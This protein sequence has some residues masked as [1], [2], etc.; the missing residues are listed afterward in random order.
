[1]KQMFGL[2]DKHIQSIHSVFKKYGDIEQAILYGSRAK[3]T[4]RNG[5]DIDLTLKGE[6]LNLTTLF[7]IEDE[8]DD[9]LIPHTVDMSIYT[10]IDNPEL[11]DH[12]KRVGIV[13]YEREK[14]DEK[15]M[16]QRPPK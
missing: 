12:I 5:S 2:S 15:P 4:Y 8:L 14:S 3:G 11:L 16:A 7:K 9:T 1:M 10:Q 13:F 6:K